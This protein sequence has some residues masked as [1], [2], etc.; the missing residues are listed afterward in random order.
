MTS[1]NDMRAAAAA[2]AANGGAETTTGGANAN[3]NRVTRTET[4]TKI[5]LS[6][7]T[8]GGGG[9]G[10]LESFPLGRGRGVS[11]DDTGEIRL[12]LGKIETKVDALGKKARDAAN[13]VDN[14]A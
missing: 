14:R 8:G 5:D 10:T 11:A 3:A 12:A 7:A 13:G 4:S 1:T 2:D 9:G 6:D